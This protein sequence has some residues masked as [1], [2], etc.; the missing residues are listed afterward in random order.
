MVRR[1]CF[2]GVHRD[3]E[4]FRKKKAMLKAIQKKIRDKFWNHEGL[5]AHGWPNLKVLKYRLNNKHRRNQRADNRR[6]KHSPKGRRRPRKL[7]KKKRA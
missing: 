1:R 6:K 4:T 2:E 3:S 5:D 7:P